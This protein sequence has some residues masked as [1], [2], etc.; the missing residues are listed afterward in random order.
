M[1]A[2]KLVGAVGAVLIAGCGRGPA[3]WSDP[4]VTPSGARGW[5]VG[6]H[7]ADLCYQLAGQDCPDGYRIVGDSAADESSAN[8]LSINGSAS[9]HYKSGKLTTLLIECRDPREQRAEPAPVRTAPAVV[10]PAP[11]ESAA[12]PLVA[13]DGGATIVTKSPF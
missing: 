11:S 6:C 1:M 8:Y 5:T 2:R 12:D 10:S 3:A 7:R 4:V 9:A 13:I